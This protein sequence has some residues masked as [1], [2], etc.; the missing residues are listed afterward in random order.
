MRVYSRAASL[1]LL[2]LLLLLVDF[3][4][5]AYVFSFFP[6][7]G[8]PLTSFGELMVFQNVLGIDFAITLALNPGMAWG[9]FGNFTNAI[10]MIRLFVIFGLLIYLFLKSRPLS[11]TIPL[12]LIV[13]GALGNVSDY[14][15]YGSVVDFLSFN[16]WGY[17]FPVFN[18]A[19]SLISIGVS[20]LFLNSLFQKKEKLSKV[21][22][23]TKTQ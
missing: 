11:T 2:A 3:F 12:V 17:R 6:F 22:A 18:V 20:F 7:T 21:V 15:I 23:V 14:F 19:D 8:G 4:S 9:F 10:L 1:I 5:K 13:T 16:L